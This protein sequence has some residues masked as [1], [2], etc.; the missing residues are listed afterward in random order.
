MRNSEYIDY[1]NPASYSSRDSLSM[2]FEFG[3]ALKASVVATSNKD[4]APWDMNFS[5][6]AFSFPL[7]GKLA[8]G[9]GL[10]PYSTINYSFIDHVRNTDTDYNPDVGELD[11]IFRGE[12]GVNQVFFGAGYKLTK[13]LS[14]GINSNYLFG[15]I[16]TVQA[17]SFMEEENSF[18]PKVESEKLLSGFNFNLGLQYYASLS[19]DW[20]ISAGAK[21]S[22]QSKI[23]IKNELKK[24][25]V[26]LLSGSGAIID[27]LLLE[28]SP[29]VK[30]LFPSS[31]G[32]GLSFNKGEKFVIGIDY[33]SVQ[34]KNSTLLNTDSLANSSSYLFGMEYTPRPKNT[35][36]YPLRI[37]YRAGAYY[38]NSYLKVHGK[39]LN[40]VGITFGAGFPIGRV[41][42]TFNISFDYGQRGSRN[43]DMV[44]EKHGM[45]IFSLSL[46]DLWFR[47]FKYQ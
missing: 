13:N 7:N 29:P 6:M 44:L 15:N 37:H 20:E 40:D 21:Y 46:Y 1:S 43:N 34:W 8:V 30:K 33:R 31:Y 23:K 25:N 24:T 9:A 12:G 17:V 41:G 27:T 32:F 22:R 2:L 26:L 18:N 47:K 42:S 19:N 3:T 38:T 14:L 45:I 11:Y 5:H 36:V 10:V 16:L 4:E 35:D 39:Q 28:T